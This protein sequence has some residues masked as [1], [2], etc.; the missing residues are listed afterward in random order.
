MADIDNSNV[1]SQMK[2]I[3]ARRAAAGLLIT[4]GFCAVYARRA[5]VRASDS[6][7]VTW[8]ATD[9]TW[10]PDGSRLAFSLYGGIWQVPA[11]GGQAEQITAS[12]GYHAHPAWS[13]K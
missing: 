10:S 12:S 9:P 6:E 11:A 13:S 4:V 2:N 7:T 3:N 1:V 5:A 8:G